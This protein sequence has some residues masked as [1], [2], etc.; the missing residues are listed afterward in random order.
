MLRQLL[1]QFR[2]HQHAPLFWL[3]IGD[4]S[5]L[6]RFIFTSDHH[7]FA[8]TVTLGQPGLDFPQFD[9]ETPQFDLK[10][11]AAEV[12]NRAIGP[13]AAEVAGS[14]HAG[15]G[16]RSKGVGQETFGRQFRA[17]EVT[18][19]DPHTADINFPRHPARNGLAVCIQ[20][21]NPGIG[22]RAANRGRIIC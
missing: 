6:T 3:Q 10:I 19:G 20:D 12:V 7:R 1:A 22:N 14:V 2:G 9:T 16:F 15:I 8:Y 4:Q 11:I 17:I 5:F 21:I 13:P 18:T